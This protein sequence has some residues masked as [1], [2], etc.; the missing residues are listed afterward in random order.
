MCPKK[1]V[2]VVV[3]SSASLPAT[4]DGPL[5]SQVVP[6]RIHVGGAAYAGGRPVSPAEFYR[7]QREAREP[8]TTAAPSPSAFVEAF[9]AAARE[10]ETVLAL[11][12]SR[13]F[14]STFDSANVAAEE[15]REESP[16]VRVEVVDTESARAARVSSRPR[17]AAPQTPATTSTRSSRR[18]ARWSRASTWPP[19]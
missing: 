15:F 3:D 18:S 2:A 5:P 4:G 17:R 19:I 6:M 14:S 10:A 9:R 13:R 16:D 1:R 11:T 8:P 7:V 12:V